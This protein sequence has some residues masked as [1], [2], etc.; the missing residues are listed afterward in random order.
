[1]IDE[2]ENLSSY[3]ES[4]IDYVNRKKEEGFSIFY[5]EE[6]ELLLDIDSKK[7]LKHCKLFLSRIKDELQDDIS[8][9]ITKST[10]PGHFHVSIKFP[11]NITPIERI[12]LQAILGSDRVREMLSLFRL[13]NGET[14]PTLLARKNT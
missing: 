4:R 1:M 2:L 10:T 6:N 8:H 9:I 3:R 11:K 13:W 7:D 5:P 14:H 12:A